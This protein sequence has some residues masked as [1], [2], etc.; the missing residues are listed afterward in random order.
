MQSRTEIE[1]LRGGRQQ[2][3]ITE[4]PYQVNK[5]AQVEKIAHLV[6]DKKI[7]GISDVRDESDRHGLRV[8]VELRRDAQ[9]EIVLNNLFRHTALRSTFNVM[10]L[11]L[12]D[13]QTSDARA[14]ASLAAVY[15]APTGSHRPPVG[16]PPKGS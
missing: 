12:V 7:E 9:A 4:L 13:G 15:R 5:A 6:R 2:I 8:V 3:I 11:A 16:T 10:M 1:E 14:Q